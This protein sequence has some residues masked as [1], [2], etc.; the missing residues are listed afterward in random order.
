MS[1]KLVGLLSPDWKPDI[2]AEPQTVDNMLAGALRLDALVKKILSDGPL[3]LEERRT[4]LAQWEADELE[5]AGDDADGPRGRE[6]ARMAGSLRAQIHLK[7]KSGNC[8]MKIGDYWAIR[9]QGRQANLKSAVGFEYLHYLLGRPNSSIS[10]F[11][12]DREID[13]LPSTESD[14]EPNGA[15]ESAFDLQNSNA[16]SAFGDLGPLVDRKTVNTVKAELKRLLEMK[17]DQLERGN[18]DRAHEID[19]EIADILSHAKG[20]QDQ[21]GRPRRTGGLEK[22]I[23]SKISMALMRAKAAISAN[24][25]DL[26]GHLERFVVFEQGEYIYKP[27]KDMK[28]SLGEILTR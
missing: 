20:F 14:I 25:P 17:G 5:R 21:T 18:A 9:F 15:Q 8:F 23:Q 11:D 24:L 26:T 7:P 27:E 28:W 4:A 12:L 1:K 13:P 6:T 19:Q 16:S 3:T 10:L 22:R 2:P